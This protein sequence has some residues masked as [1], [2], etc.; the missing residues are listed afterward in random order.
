MWI[1]RI[2]KVQDRVTKIYGYFNNHFHGYAVE[3]CIEILEMLNVATPL[4]KRVKE[5][6]RRHDQKKPLT[7]EK[8]LDD[9]RVITETPLETHLL[10]LADLHR[11]KRGMKIRDEEVTFQKLSD[12]EIRVQIRNYVVEIDLIEKIIKHNCDDWQKGLDSKRFCKHLVK[13][14]L[15]M[16][17]KESM[18]ILMDVSG[19]RNEWQF[20]LV[21]DG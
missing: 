2:K 6:V 8:K 14:F 19:S 3:N 21:S 9:F 16:A 7:F 11:L 20:Q 12:E 13:I 5:R 1:P 10:H 15:L 4:Q 17:S 18:R